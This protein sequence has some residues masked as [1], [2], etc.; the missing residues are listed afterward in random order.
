MPYLEQCLNSL[1]N[2]TVRDIEIVCVNDCSP[3]NS[4]KVIRDY[5]AKD[6]RIKLINHEENRHQGGAWN[7]G[8]K[9]ATGDYLCFVDADDWLE[10]D[11]C[12]VVELGADIIIAK[13]FYKGF[14][15]SD[16]I[17]E[18]KFADCGYDIRKNILLNGLFFITNFYK[19]SLFERLVFHFVE[20]NAY[21]D[22][23]TTL[24]YFK[25]ENIKFTEK[26]GYHYRVDNV[27][28]QRS[29]NQNAFW[30]RLDTAK[31]EYNSLKKMDIAQQYESEIDYHFYKLFY[32]NSLIRAYYG[33]TKINW[34]FV[35][36]IIEEKKRLIPNIEENSYVSK[37]NSDYSFIMRLPLYMFDAIPKYMIDASHWFYIL[38]RKIAR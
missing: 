9:A 26:V 16:N 34:K 18:R 7:T 19:R 21:H 31:L 33:F 12:E 23:M 25:T 5:S 20:N 13:K 8:V 4:E 24:L 22:F 35:D 29:M 27:S 6:S 11:Y 1:I 3:D 17:D 10:Y 37:L 2:Q 32:C 15:K 14:V 28:L 30:G 38:L 36:C